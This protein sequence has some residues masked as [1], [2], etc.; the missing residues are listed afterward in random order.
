MDTT[1]VESISGG[2]AAVPGMYGLVCWIR[3]SFHAQRMARR[4]RETHEE[5]WKE[6][7]WLT[8]RNP[9]AGIEVLVSKGLIS[10]PEVNEYRARDE[11]LG[12]ATW[13]G[14]LV[15]AALLLAIILG[16][17]AITSFS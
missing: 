10:G 7:H 3:R 5:Q 17:I 12:K 9:W 4:V 15:S 8:R 16:K 11:Y 13:A 1:T 14:F 6:L 2:I